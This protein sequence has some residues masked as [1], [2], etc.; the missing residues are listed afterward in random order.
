MIFLQ[1][2]FTL[3]AYLMG[4]VTLMVYSFHFLLRKFK[5]LQPFFINHSRK[6]ARKVWK[7]KTSSR[8]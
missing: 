1:L 8:I 7:F 6:V 3:H 2:P 4:G 5:N